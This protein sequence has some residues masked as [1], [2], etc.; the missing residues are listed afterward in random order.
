MFAWETD[1]MRHF[2]YFAK[3]CDDGLEVIFECVFSLSWEQGPNDMK[4]K[5]CYLIVLGVQI[6]IDH[7][8]E[9]IVW[10]FEW[11]W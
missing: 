9:V 8:L 4:E 1:R 6:K 5:Y 11:D 7:K 2:W 3:H 10:V